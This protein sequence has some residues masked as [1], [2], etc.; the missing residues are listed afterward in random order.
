MS[1][2]QTFSKVASHLFHRTGTIECQQGELGGGRSVGEKLYLPNPL[3][4]KQPMRFND[5]SQER[6]QTLISF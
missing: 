1:C 5:L 2:Q 4:E 6:R 3:H